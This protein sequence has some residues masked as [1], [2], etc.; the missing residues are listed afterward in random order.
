MISRML[1]YVPV[2]RPRMAKSISRTF[3]VRSHVNAAPC[4]SYQNVDSWM[5]A[6]SRMPAIDKERA[7]ISEMKGPKLGIA[8]ASKT[9]NEI[10]R[11]LYKIDF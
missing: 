4:R 10:H 7:P 9:G 6:G 5:A 3:L 11:F 1:A 2:T 8:T